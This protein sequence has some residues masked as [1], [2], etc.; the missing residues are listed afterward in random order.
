MPRAPRKCPRP[1]CDNRITNT[2]YCEEHTEAHWSRGPDRTNTRAHKTWQTAV[3]RRCKHRCEI[4]GPRCTGVATIA[5]HIIPNAEGGTTT[6]DNGQGTCPPCHADK[7]KQEATR[8]LR[9]AY[10]HTA[11][12]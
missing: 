10:G 11:P 8:G 6:L 1:G 4:R 9:R 5:D 12:F 2:R 7:T 3:L